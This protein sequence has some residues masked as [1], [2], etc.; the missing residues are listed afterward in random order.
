MSLSIIFPIDMNSD[1]NAGIAGHP[2]DDTTSA[3]KQN[4]KM[5]LLTRKGEYVFDP[6]FGVGLAGFLFENDAT[7]SIPLI[8]GEIRNQTAT[9]MPYVQIDGINIQIDS[10]NQIL[11]TQIRFRYNGLSI[12]ELFEVEVS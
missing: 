7:I 8:E 5:L 2:N 11:R 10:D 1:S 4:M 9:Y 6:K 3:I 12:P